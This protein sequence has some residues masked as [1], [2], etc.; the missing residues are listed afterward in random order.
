MILRE[1][2]RHPFNST[3]NFSNQHLQEDPSVNEEWLGSGEK[4][5]SFIRFSTSG[6]RLPESCPRLEATTWKAGRA[7]GAEGGQCP[8]PKGK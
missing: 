7:D 2:T 4:G 5:H 6:L 8:P 3:S 1:A